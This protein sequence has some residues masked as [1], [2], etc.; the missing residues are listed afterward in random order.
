M[1]IVMSG[2]ISDLLAGVTAF[3]ATNLDDI[4]ILVLFF[5]QINK[6]FRPKHIVVGQY[7]G[8]SALILV[9]LPGFFGG[10]IVPKIW[11][12]LLGLIPI[13]IGLYQLIH[14]EADDDVQ[15][16]SNDLRESKIKRSVLSAFGWLAPQSYQVAA[17]TI[18]N[19]GDN[20]G[21]YLPLFA[22]SSVARLGVILSVFFA[23]VGVWCYGGYQLARHPIVERVLVRYGSR[24]VP[25]VLIG[26]G[27]FILVDSGTHKL[28]TVY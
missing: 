13:A 4:V 11:I 2:L 15:M 19:G 27:I 26:L 24:V 17:V 16:I 12:G 25:F 1:C 20:I 21:I 14:R 23:M 8:F 5:A 18:A 7:L 9:S 10:L 28:L 22:N 3:I 6:T